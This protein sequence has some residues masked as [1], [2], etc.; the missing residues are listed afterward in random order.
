VDPIHAGEVEDD[1]SA[2]G[3]RLAV[4]AGACAARGH[5]DVECEAAGEDA[6]DLIGRDRLHDGVGDLVVEQLFQDRRVPVEVA[7]EALHGLRIRDDLL[8]RGDARV[9]RFEI[10]G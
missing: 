4:V 3:D 1:A 10:V 2:Q 8:R 6:N 5:G 7:R 9:E